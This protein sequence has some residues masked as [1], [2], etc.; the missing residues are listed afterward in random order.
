[1]PSSTRRSA[2]AIRCW[3]A[4]WRS[5][6]PPR[7]CRGSALRWRAGP[8]TS[9]RARRRPTGRLAACALTDMAW[10]DHEKVRATESFLRLLQFPFIG[11]SHPE[12]AFLAV[13]VM[14]RYGGSVDAMVLDT[15]KGLVSASQLKRAEILGRVLLL[16]HRFGQRA[17]NSRGGAGADR[18]RRGPAR[19]AERR[20]DPRQRSGAVA[21]A[22]ARQG[23]WRR[24]RRGGRR[25][26]LIW[27]RSGHTPP[28]C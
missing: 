17:G 24:P 5:A 16:G 10:R 18:C 12:R 2:T 1:M 23:Q 8:T 6:C 3:R 7:G 15:L 25:R 4:R 28:S 22:A 14:A 21:A 11:I 26:R 13:A 19:G 20:A 27:A 9:F